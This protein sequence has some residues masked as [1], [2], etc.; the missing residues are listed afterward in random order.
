[1][2]DVSVA[3]FTI[4]VGLLVLGCHS[5]SVTR[6]DNTTYP[7]TD[8]I[9]VF[10]DPST[11]SEPYV[12]IGYVEAKGGITVSKQSLLDDMVEQAKQHG[13]NALVKVEFYDRPQYNEGLGHIEKPAAKAIMIRYKSQLPK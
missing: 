13:A 5:A 3:L 10:T 12:E 4:V 2:K 8:S 9:Q 1:M 6:F 7:P 11:V